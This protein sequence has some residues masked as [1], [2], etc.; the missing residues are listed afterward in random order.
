MSIIDHI[1]DSGNADDGGE[2]LLEDGVFG[3]EYPAMFEFMS[4]H[5]YKGNARATGRVILYCEPGKGCVCLSD[6]HTGQVAFHVADT[7]AEAMEGMERRL[8]S[9]K[10]DWRKDKRSQFRR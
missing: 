1:V 6:K 9:G 8:A 4:R 10:C 3:A 5:R 2:F 7:L